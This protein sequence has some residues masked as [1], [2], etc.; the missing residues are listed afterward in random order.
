[1]KLQEGKPMFYIKIELQ[2]THNL[3]AAG[4]NFNPATNQVPENTTVV[5]E[6]DD[7]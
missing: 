2:T 3:K 4:L 6:A 5:R 7:S 1:M